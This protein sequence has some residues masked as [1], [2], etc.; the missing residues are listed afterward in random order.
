MKISNR[1]KR[2]KRQKMP[3]PRK[4]KMPVPKKQKTPI[5]IFLIITIAAL[6]TLKYLKFISF[7]E[8]IIYTLSII[9]LK[10]LIS[11]KIKSSLSIKEY[12][13]T[14][15]FVEKKKNTYPSPS[16]WTLLVAII[17]I[18]LQ[19]FFSKDNVSEKI[20]DI[21][22]KNDPSVQISTLLK[23]QEKYFTHAFTYKYMGLD[24][25]GKVLYIIL[26]FN[27]NII[28]NIVNYPIYKRN[29]IRNYCI[30]E[31]NINDENKIQI[32]SDLFFFLYFIHK[33]TGDSTILE[34]AESYTET[35][36]DYVSLVEHIKNDKISSQKN[37]YHKYATEISFYLVHSILKNDEKREFFTS[38]LPEKNEYT[39]TLS[40]LQNLY[41]YEKIEVM[42]NI[43]DKYNEM[44]LQNV[45]ANLESSI[46]LYTN[47]IKESHN[48]LKNYLEKLFNINLTI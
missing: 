21:P 27:D 28:N 19:A 14:F 44:G 12:L 18:I 32:M 10:I 30:N 37:I 40:V 8:L 31:L 45:F 34:M 13:F 26:G 3:A 36:K 42:E 17:G 29:N 5:P 24:V 2:K 43:F 41:P 1:C 22:E 25:T 15:F 23:I 16:L 48:S 4:Q 47:Q 6:M 46:H 38:I 35:I 39:L 7:G 9:G 11:Y 33:K 20:I